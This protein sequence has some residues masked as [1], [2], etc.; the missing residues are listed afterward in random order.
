[1]KLTVEISLYPLQDD[2]IPDLVLD[3]DVEFRVNTEN[4]VNGNQ[5]IQWWAQVAETQL[6]H[7]GNKHATQWRSNDSVGICLRWARDAMFIPAP[8]QRSEQARVNGRQVCYVFAGR[9]ALLRLLSMHAATPADRGRRSFLRPHTLRFETE[10]SLASAQRSA[11]NLL[12]TDTRVYIRVGVILPGA[13][14]AF[15]MPEFPR[16]APELS[17]EVLRQNGIVPNKVAGG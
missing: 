3:I 7:R 9:W 6:D 8:N 5:I 11:A 1:M 14:S 10:T 13:K 4:E 2:Y 15:K 16:R 17:T 12:V